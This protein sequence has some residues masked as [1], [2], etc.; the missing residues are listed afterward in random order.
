MIV[1]VPVYIAIDHDGRNIGGPYY[2]RPAEEVRL[3]IRFD[4]EN[5]NETIKFCKLYGRT[6]GAWCDDTGDVFATSFSNISYTKLLKKIAENPDDYAP[7][8]P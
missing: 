5:N 3:L 4:T 1:E 8:T 6:R 7:V 2:P